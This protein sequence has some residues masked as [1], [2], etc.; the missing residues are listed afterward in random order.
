MD[1][2]LTRSPKVVQVALTLFFPGALHLSGT[3]KSADT[4]RGGRRIQVKKKSASSPADAVRELW[5]VMRHYAT[6][7]WEICRIVAGCLRD[8]PACYT[9]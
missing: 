8:S 6:G 2:H 7:R 4:A 3:Q 9:L 5:H 1:R